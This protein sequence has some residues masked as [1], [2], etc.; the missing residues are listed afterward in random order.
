MST[1]DRTTKAVLVTIALGLWV[2]IGVSVLRPLPAVAQS[3][4]ITNLLQEI[5]NDVFDLAE[6]SCANH[7]ICR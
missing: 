6:G 2:N 7:K 5:Q 3:S 1:I 4:E